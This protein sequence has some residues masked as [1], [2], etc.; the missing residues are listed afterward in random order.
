MLPCCID[1]EADTRP[2]RTAACRAQF[3]IWVYCNDSGATVGHLLA[4]RHNKPLWPK[5]TKHLDIPHAALRSAAGVRMPKIRA[6]PARRAAQQHV[7]RCATKQQGHLA[8]ASRRFAAKRDAV[9]TAPLSRVSALQP[10]RLAPLRALAQGALPQR[11]KRLTHE[12]TSPCRQAKASPLRDAN[13][14]LEPLALALWWSL[15]PPPQP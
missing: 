11:P 5:E 13:C 10:L 3:S 4:K 12:S 9:R 1:F 14:S 15:E 7:R 8:M 2:R 6:Q